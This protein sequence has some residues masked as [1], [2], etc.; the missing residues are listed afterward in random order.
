MGTISGEEE[1]MNKAGRFNHLRKEE[2]EDSAC[3][4]ALGIIEH[5]WLS[6]GFSA[7]PGIAR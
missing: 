7:T 5:I 2:G 3:C 1:A 4:V 6:D